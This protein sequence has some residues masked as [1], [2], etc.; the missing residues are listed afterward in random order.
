MSD[1]LE[2]IAQI[3]SKIKALQDQIPGYEAA[4]KDWRSSADAITCSGTKKKKAAC[5]QDKV[6][7]YQ[8]ADQRQAQANNLKSQVAALQN[9]KKALEAA[10]EAQNTANVNLSEHGE[11]LEAKLIESQGKA[12]AT[13]EAAKIQAAANADATRQAAATKAETDAQTANTMNYIFIGIGVVVVVVVAAIVFTKLR[14][15]KKK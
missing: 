15:K 3:T 1:Y 7:R 9:D 13:L 11:S 4:A 8:Q 12:D 2:K 10:Q 14:K 6:W 5:E